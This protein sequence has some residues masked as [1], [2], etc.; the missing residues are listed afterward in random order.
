MSRGW[1]AFPA[2][3]GFPIPEELFS[4]GSGHPVHTMMHR[5]FFFVFILLSYN[6][7]HHSLPPLLSSH[8]PLPSPFHCSSVSFQKRTAQ[9]DAIE[10]ST[11]PHSKAVLDNP[12]RGKGFHEQAKESESPSSYCKEFCNITNLSRH[13]EDL[14]QALAGSMIAVQFL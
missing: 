11:N 13:A 2:S 6:I 5:Q 1:R 10:L 14:A 12:V 4:K 3:P 8:F 7:S 9:Q